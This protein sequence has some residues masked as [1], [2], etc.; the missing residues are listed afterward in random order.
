[1]ELLK[2]KL[3]DD[4]K[5]ET[6]KMLRGLAKNIIDSPMSLESQNLYAE[7]K[8]KEFVVT[9]LV[10]L[11]EERY[12]E[13]ITDSARSGKCITLGEYVVD[14][15]V[16]SLKCGLRDIL[17]NYDYQGKVQPDKV[18]ELLN[19]IDVAL[20]VN[21]FKNTAKGG[22]GPAKKRRKDYNMYPD[23][24]YNQS[25]FVQLKIKVSREERAQL[26]RIAIIYLVLTTGNC[27]NLQLVVE[28]NPFD[29]GVY[30]MFSKFETI[31]DHFTAF[32]RQERGIILP[33][34]TKMVVDTPTGTI[35]SN[36]T[37]TEAAA[38]TAAAGGGGVDENSST[39]EDTE[40]TSDLVDNV[41]IDNTET[42]PAAP[43]AA[44]GVVDES[45]GAV[46]P[47]AEDDDCID[48]GNNFTGYGEDEGEGE[49]DEKPPTFFGGTPSFLLRLLLH[50]SC[51]A[52]HCHLTIPGL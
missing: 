15:I 22:S 36:N 19:E 18:R 47:D 28:D 42:T 29:G 14:K 44:G 2:T 5:Y 35:D 40:E 7:R 38:P 23:K 46:A 31:A 10:D 51:R 37:E 17:S 4:K 32:G 33:E 3:S 8:I 25:V 9:H 34:G 43:T 24:V 16:A 21:G 13:K 39:E 6:V 1:M 20:E 41:E 30:I 50:T 11:N 12:K 52:T 45:S 49:D 48:F 27:S 26:E